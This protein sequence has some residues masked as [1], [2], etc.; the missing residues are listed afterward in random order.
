MSYTGIHPDGDSPRSLLK[1][2]GLPIF[3]PQSQRIMVYI[4]MA[5]GANPRPIWVLHPD[6]D[7]LGNL[8]K[9]EGSLTSI[10]Q[11]QPIM[12]YTLM[13]ARADSQ[14]IWVFT[15]MATLWGV[16]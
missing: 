5:T 2:G 16:S 4:M 7:S 11:S 10:T 3:I 14:P 9:D 13:A 1:D 15:L 8:L 6:T 12:G